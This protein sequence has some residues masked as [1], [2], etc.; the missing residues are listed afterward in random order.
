MIFAIRM[1]R[2]GELMQ[3]GTVHRLM[4]AEGAALRPG[5][6]LLEVRVALEQSQAQ[7]CPPLLFFRIIA[8]ERGFLRKLSAAPGDVLD[9]NSILGVA[10]T[11]LE[12][13]SA[14]PAARGLRTTAVV[15]QIDPLAT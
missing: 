4:A 2:T 3:V 11:T 12:E 13:T 15:I 6:P 8:T 9:V 10:T 1:P 7:D 14:G 5:T